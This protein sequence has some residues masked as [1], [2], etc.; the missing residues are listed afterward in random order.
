MRLGALGQ[1]CSSALQRH[2]CVGV[3]GSKG[4]QASLARIGTASPLYYACQ[5]GSLAFGSEQKAI[6]AQPE[7]R[8]A[9]SWM[10]RLCWNISRSEHLHGP[11]AFKG[12]PYSPGR[13]LRDIFRSQSEPQLHRYW[14]YRFREPDKAIDKQAYLEELDRL[15][16]QSCNASACRRRRTWSLSQR[17][18]GQRLHHGNRRAII[19]QSQD[20]YLWL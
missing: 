9:A 7:F 12:Y 17:R 1:R 3:M 4:A 2:V 19:S 6:T 13:A 11:D 20:L 14:D 8:L 10:R 16:R 5:N 18:D 15:F